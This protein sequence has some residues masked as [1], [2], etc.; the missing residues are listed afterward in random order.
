MLW[1]VTACICQAVPAAMPSAAFLSLGKMARFAYFMI[2]ISHFSYDVLELIQ[3]SFL[4]GFIWKW[5]CP[6]HIPYPLHILCPSHATGFI[7][8][9]SVQSP[10]WWTMPISYIFFS[11]C[12]LKSFPS[13]AWVSSSSLSSGAPVSPTSSWALY[14]PRC[15]VWFPNAVLWG[16]LSEF[17]ENREHLVLVSARALNTLEESLFWWSHLMGGRWC[18]SPPIAMETRKLEETRYHVHGALGSYEQMSV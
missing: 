5:H 6:A 16:K 3:H 9:Q 15:S 11:Y 18:C 13:Q 12:F 14:F 2:T 4:Y 10:G 8:W 17:A 1:S 7:G